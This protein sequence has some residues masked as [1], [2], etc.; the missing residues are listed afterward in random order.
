M[1][2][3]RLELV[4]DGVFAIVLTLLVLNLK[5][6]TAHGLASLREAMPGLLV[7]AAVFFLVGIMWMGHHAA[8]ARVDSVSYRALLFNLLALF[9]VTLLPFAAE[10][11]VDRPSEPLGASL[12]AFCCGAYMISFMAMRLS[13]HS[14]IDD[15]PEMRRWRR[16]RIVIASFV[17]VINLACAVLAWASPWI[18]YLG[19][20]ALVFIFVVLRSPPAAEDR[21]RELAVEAE[22]A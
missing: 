13:A 7:H 4:S 16:T 17:V 8:L 11:A 14:V 5:V 2:K 3:S 21:F 9:W 18:G 22:S 12:I 1:S 15:V 19:A 6:P 20:L 10:N